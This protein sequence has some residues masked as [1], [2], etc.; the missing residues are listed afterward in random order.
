MCVPVTNQS[1]HGIVRPSVR[2]CEEA[3]DKGV[4][5]QGGMN[6]NMHVLFQFGGVCSG[7]SWS[8]CV[9]IALVR[10]LIRGQAG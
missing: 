9:T 6:T 10:D 2:A 4:S 8:E 7:Y 1:V 5:G 3:V